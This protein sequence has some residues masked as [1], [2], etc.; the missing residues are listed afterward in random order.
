[1]L[2][3]VAANDVAFSA[4]EIDSLKYCA[5]AVSALSF[6]GSFLVVWSYFRFA[7]LQKFAFK[8]ICM[9]AI[10]DL[11]SGLGYFIGSPPNGALCTAQGIILHYF[12]LSSFLWTTVIAFVLERTVCRQQGQTVQENRVYLHLY[13]WGLPLIL[14]LLPFTTAHKMPHGLAYSNT[15]E[16]WSESQDGAW[17]W[18]ADDDASGGIGTAWR[19]FTFYAPL[20][21]CMCY[22]LWSYNKVITT[23][24]ITLNSQ[25]QAHVHAQSATQTQTQMRAYE[26]HQTKIKIVRRLRWYPALLVVCWTFATINRV[27]NAVN[28]KGRPIFWLYILHATFS[29]AQGLCNSVVY[30]LNKGV[31]AAWREEYT[32]SA[33]HFDGAYDRISRCCT[34]CYGY[35]KQATMVE[36]KPMRPPKVVLSKASNVVSV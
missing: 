24:R 12:Q 13:A 27:Q 33:A 8:L 11:G 6:I 19:F 2:D 5:I 29:S 7:R 21:S 32:A 20:W 34:T 26:Q 3:V 25:T 35:E 10:S 28:T 30:G 15:F 1:M 22:N 17:C 4:L 36:A 23:L 31:Q 16:G 18:I 14:V 9:L